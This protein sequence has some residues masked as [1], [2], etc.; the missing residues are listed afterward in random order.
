M[1]IFRKIQCGFTLIELSLIIAIIGIISAIAFASLTQSRYTSRLRAAQRE[2]ASTVKLAQTYALQ[3]KSQSGVTVC[4]YVFRFIDATNYEIFYNVVGG[5]LNC[6]DRNGVV[7][8]SGR[9]WIG[10]GPNA[11]LPAESQSL[12]NGV[13]LD[14][15][16]SPLNKTEFYF[17]IPHAD[18]YDQQGQ[19]FSGSQIF[20]FI[21]SGNTKD[22]TISSGGYVT[23]S[24]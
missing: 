14:T 6:E 15:I 10:V 11:S 20:R 16:F 13:T 9:H 3:G 17:T 2:V 24:Q 4:G 7:D 1:P 19:S 22:V 21:I 23:E 8:G 12:K 5:Y 18:I